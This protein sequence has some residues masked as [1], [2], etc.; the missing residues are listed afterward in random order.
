MHSLLANVSTAK[1]LLGKLNGRRRWRRPLGRVR[2]WVERRWGE[3]CGGRGWVLGFG[4]L[5]YDRAEGGTRIGK[6]L[7]TLSLGLI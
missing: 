7:R 6:S 2:V 1:T 5:S 3:G 4:G